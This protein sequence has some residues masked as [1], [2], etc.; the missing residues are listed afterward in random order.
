VA[1]LDTTGARRATFN[2]GR[3]TVGDSPDDAGFSVWAP[4][5][6]TSMVR[7]GIGHGAVGDLPL[8]TVLNMADRQGRN[9]IQLRVAE[10]GTPALQMFD[11]DGNVTW[12]AR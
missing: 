7:L 1:V 10:D 6:T 3:N 2:T 4:D 8:A 9:R 12:S 5:G 11:A